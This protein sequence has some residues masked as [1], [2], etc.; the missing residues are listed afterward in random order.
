M[1][2]CGLRVSDVSNVRWEAIDITQGTLCVHNR[3][4]PV[5]R[6]VYTGWRREGPLPSSI[7][8]RGQRV[9]ILPNL[10]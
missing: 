5:D 7:S 9:S 1:L 3:K 10:I 2:R 6:M 8:G 4:G